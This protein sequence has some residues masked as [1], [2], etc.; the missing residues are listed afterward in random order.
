MVFDRHR[1][2]G[3][4]CLR[5]APVRRSRASLSQP[6]PARAARIQLNSS[7]RLIEMLVAKWRT[8]ERLRRTGRGVEDGHLVVEVPD[9]KGGADSRAGQ[10]T[11]D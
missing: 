4:R 3:G 2:S 5:K 6:E 11:T 10:S 1:M 7:D 8:P 9:A